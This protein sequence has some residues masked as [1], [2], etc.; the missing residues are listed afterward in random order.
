MNWQKLAAYVY[1]CICVFD[2]VVV[3][4]WFGIVRADMPMSVEQL[5][6]FDVAVQIRMIEAFTFQ[7]LPFTLQGGGLFHLAFGALLTGSTIFSH[8]KD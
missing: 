6:E 8:K 3:P 2:F 5:L 7:H 1:L 4:I